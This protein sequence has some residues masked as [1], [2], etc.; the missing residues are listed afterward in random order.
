MKATIEVTGWESSI[1]RPL[2]VKSAADINKIFKSA[3][4]VVPLTESIFG[5][6]A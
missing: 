5:K 3:K 1:M 2:V 6:K 4:T